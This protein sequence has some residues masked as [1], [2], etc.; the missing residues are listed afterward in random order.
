MDKR[1]C[2][3]AAAVG[4]TDGSF[5]SEGY[6]SANGGKIYVN[7][8]LYDYIDP[9]AS[10][11]KPYDDLIDFYD[12]TSYS[13][14]PYHHRL[15][16]NRLGKLLF[17][18]DESDN[19]MSSDYIDP[20]RAWAHTK[21]GITDAEIGEMLL[22]A[23]TIS[24]HMLWPV[25]KI[26]TINTARGGRSG[27]YDRIDLTLQ[28]IRYMKTDDLQSRNRAVRNAIEKEKAWFSL[29]MKAS[30]LDGFKNFVDLFRLN[31]FVY[32]DDYSVISLVASNL[33][34]GI[35]V[36]VSTDQ[37]VFPVDFRMY[38]KNNLIA[39]EKQA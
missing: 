10:C 7:G 18:E 5:K 33:T 26:P 22:R 16:K 15:K 28:E 29:F 24:R 11:D 31:S 34:E 9:D 27:F 35:Y 36:P 14:T 21:G 20:S 38:V 4:E 2:Y 23:R 13:H 25:H 30:G 19:R 37:P 8:T 1:Y 39:I 6:S 17:L 12:M 3:L 32:G